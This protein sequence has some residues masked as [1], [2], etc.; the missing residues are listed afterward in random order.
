MAEEIQSFQQVMSVLDPLPV[1]NS[2]K[3]AAF[4]AFYDAPNAQEFQKR[5]DRINIPRE[6]KA[7][8]WDQ[9][10]GREQQQLKK[11]QEMGTPEFMGK[12]AVAE[13]PAIGATIGGVT[14][15]IPG[16]A[17]GG[18]LG[19]AA[20]RAIQYK[21]GE[22]PP[23]K[24]GEFARDIAGAGLAQAGY[25]AGGRAAGAG[26]GLLRRAA[27]PAYAASLK[28][29]EVSGLEGRDLERALA[30]R[31][32]VTRRGLET[33]K[34]WQGDRAGTAEARVTAAKPQV[35]AEV[36][37][38]TE[39][40]KT[41]R[42]EDM[43]KPMRDKIAL[44][45]ADDPAE[46]KALEKQY[47]RIMETLRDKG[48]DQWMTVKEAQDWKE[49]LS[50]Q[51]SSKEFR[52]GAPSAGKIA[53]KTARY[54]GLKETIEQAAPGVEEVNRAI[55]LDLALKDAIN[56]AEASHPGWLR[57]TI[58]SLVGAGALTAVGHHGMAEALIVGHIVRNAV[59][60]PAVMSKLAVALE[61]AGVT[62]PKIAEPT[63]KYGLRFGVPL[64]EPMPPSRFD[65]QSP[66]Q[67]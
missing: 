53:G 65:Q 26:L 11:I 5:F 63:V 59:S 16:A 58:P 27:E 10:F 3:A 45:R 57:D 40:G 7:A 28:F 64:T 1:D 43:M 30:E 14:M 39:A 46:A 6:A 47:N 52:G 49:I 20:K 15:G 44:W 13:L 29:P 9:K 56:K 19:Q 60:Q 23:A 36:A 34:F 55:H 22:A 4:D 18:A 2:A 66:Q 51:T 42:T 61:R 12:T 8:L 21:M 31:K 17:G 62:L 32:A 24:A 33:E 48:M 35:T 41:I 50:R 54:G 37:Q 25:E 67:P 38:A